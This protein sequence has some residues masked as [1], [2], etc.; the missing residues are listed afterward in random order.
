MRFARR[1]R[2]RYLDADET[3]DLIHQEPFKIVVNGQVEVPAGG[4]LKVPT[5]RV[6]QLGLGRPPVRARACF[7]R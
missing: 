6:N 3:G 2:Q 1:L 7:M 5:P 4:Q